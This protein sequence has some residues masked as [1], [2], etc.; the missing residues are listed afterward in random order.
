MICQNTTYLSHKS[1]PDLNFWIKP[2]KVTCD[3]N[4]L[5]F[6]INMSTLVTSFSLAFSVDENSGSDTFFFF[7]QFGWTFSNRNFLT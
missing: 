3:V 2:L 6:P 5:C 7:V 4:A 1:G